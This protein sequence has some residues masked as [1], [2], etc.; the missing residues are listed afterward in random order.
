[1]AHFGEQLFSAI[2][3]RLC[4]WLLWVLDM[5]SP[6]IDSSDSG[7]SSSGGASPVSLESSAG[8]HSFSKLNTRF[9]TLARH[10]AAGDRC[11]GEFAQFINARIQAEKAY[12]ESLQ[13]IGNMNVGAEEIGTM[14]EGVCVN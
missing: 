2:K 11:L 3:A 1:M 5:S 9:S 13:K 4:T 8:H 10:L 7:G 12:A 14:S 6:T